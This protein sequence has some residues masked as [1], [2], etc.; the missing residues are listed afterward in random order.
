MPTWGFIV[1]P[2]HHERWDG[3]GYPDYYRGENALTTNGN[4]AAGGHSA[5]PSSQGISLRSAL[6]AFASPG[7][8]DRI[9]DTDQL[10]LAVGGNDRAR[11]FESA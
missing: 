1:V 7:L 9:D 2:S 5:P 10:S 11:R 6:A 8:R 3:S 4:T